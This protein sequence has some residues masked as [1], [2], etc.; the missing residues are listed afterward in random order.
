MHD[1]LLDMH[2]NETDL[3]S[4]PVKKAGGLTLTA[5]EE[6]LTQQ[7]RA[8]VTVVQ[9]LHPQLAGPCTMLFPT[10]LATAAIHVAS[11][12]GRQVAVLD[13]G[14]SVTVANANTLDPSHLNTDERIVLEAMNETS[15]KPRG[16]RRPCSPS[17][18]IDQV[19]ELAA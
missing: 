5:S 6:T 1:V 13:S 7:G 10:K 15:L 3:N 12:A 4:A 17:R 19:H 18:T 8:A 16:L 11:S 2:V 14:A 9:M